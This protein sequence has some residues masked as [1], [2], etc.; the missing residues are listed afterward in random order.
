DRYFLNRLISRLLYLRDG[1]CTSYEGNYADYQAHVVA[2]AAAQT[3]TP[4]AKKTPQGSPRQQSR[5]VKRRKPRA[6]EQD[7]SRIEAELTALQA[8]IEPQNGADWKR[9][10]ELS[11]QKSTLAARLE[12]LMAEGEQSMAT[13]GGGGCRR[14]LRPPRAAERRENGDPPR[15]CVR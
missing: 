1:T 3:Q 7:I 10:T 6:I 13:E 12:G 4:S 2:Q 5:P 15:Q 8:P 14:Q 9:L 11:T